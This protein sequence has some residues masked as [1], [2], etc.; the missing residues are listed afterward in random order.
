M[1]TI[2]WNKKKITYPTKFEDVSLETYLRIFNN[3]DKIQESIQE[4]NIIDKTEFIALVLNIPY[5]DA[6]QL[7]M[8]IFEGVKFLLEESIF[9]NIFDKDFKI[10]L[11]KLP[12]KIK[13]QGKVIDIEKQTSVTNWTVGQSQYIEYVLMAIENKLKNT[14]LNAILSKLHQSIELTNEETTVYIKYITD[15]YNGYFNRITDIIAC[16]I[17]PA[18]YGKFD[19]DKVKDLSDYVMELPV[20]DISGIGFFLWTNLNPLLGDFLKSSEGSKLFKTLAIQSADMRLFLNML[21]NVIQI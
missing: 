7:P 15:T 2:K 8:T 18:V 16:V 4:D 19:G 20:K 11:D 1:K 12:K 5:E 13:I 9:D 14:E 17:M 21:N 3:F 10:K 6:N